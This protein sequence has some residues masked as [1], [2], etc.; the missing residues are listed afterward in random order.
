M[1]SSPSHRKQIKH[2]HQPGDFHEFTFSCYQRKSLLSN[3]TWRTYLSRSIDEA[4]DPDEYRLVTFVFMP[5]HVHLLVYPV[6]E[7]PD[8][9]RFLATIKLP[10]SQQVKQALT[11]SGSRLLSQLTVRER[12]GKLTFRFWQEGP[13]YD[14]NLQTEQSVLAAINYIHLNP[15]R[16]NLCSQAREWRWSSA[17]WYET[18]GRHQDSALPTIHGVP[19]GFR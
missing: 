16:R 8:I 2:Y 19:A 4:C 14:R 5:E 18:D 15:V 11:L 10:V 1:S 9:G 6:E 3:D 7:E 17:R 13:G 12:P